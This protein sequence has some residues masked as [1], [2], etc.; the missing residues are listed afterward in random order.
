MFV[1]MF[2]LM[3]AFTSAATANFNSDDG[4]YGSYG[5]DTAWPE[6]LGGEG[7]STV[8]LIENTDH[9]LVD[10]HAILEFNNTNEVNLMDGL[11]FLGEEMMRYREE[12]GLPNRLPPLFQS[13]ANQLS[14]PIL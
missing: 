3:F 10:C 4:T 14:I 8:E 7:E 5:I 12:K 9:C 13:S 2:V 1:L 6:W 11:E